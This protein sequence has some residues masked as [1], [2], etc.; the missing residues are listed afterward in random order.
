[1]QAL[2]YHPLERI[3]VPRPVERIDYIVAGC[4]GR[5]VLDLGA[6]DE[7]LI[8]KP[9]HASWKWLHAEVARSAAAILG[10]DASED[11][12]AK[13]EIRTEAGTSILYG[14][15]EDIDAI[16]RDFRPDVI[17]AGEL[18]E[19]TPD[20]LGWLTKAGR[21]APGAKLLATTPNA[22]SILNILLSFLSRE[23]QHEDHLHVY[24]Y[25][26]LATLAQRLALTE[27]KLTPYYYHSEQFRGR[28]PRSV[29]PII[30]A[31]DY[32]VLMPI[33]YLFPLTAFGLILEG[34]FPE[35]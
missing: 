14:R 4:A 2:E 15:V 34:R 30:S 27:P 5:R 20:T 33:Q 11:V 32:M 24:S 12:R 26:T 28:V 1:M 35:R 3:R 22:T 8:G 16:I 19:H 10:I 6:L 17:L 25:K 7:T 23:S 18:I 29:A 31:I 13:G 21:A 9:Q